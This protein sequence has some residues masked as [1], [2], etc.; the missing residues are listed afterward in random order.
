MRALPDDRLRLSPS[1]L[2]NFLACRHLTSLD[3]RRARGEIVLD[4]A[5]RPDAALIA[6]KGQRHEEA[7]LEALKAEGKQVVAI[8][9]FGDNGADPQTSARATEQAMRTGAE[10]V[11]QAAFLDDDWLG[12]ADFL[13][14]IDEPSALGDWSYEAY[15]TKLARYPKPYFILQLAF[16][17]EQIGRIQGR[18]PVQMHVV[19]G[20]REVKSFRYDDFAAYVAHVRHQFLD[21][22]ASDGP[23]PYPYPVEHCDYCDWWKRCKDKRRADDH[24][25]LVAALTRQQSIRLEDGGVETVAALAALPDDATVQRLPRTTLDALHQQARLQVYT[26][27]TGE[28]IREFLPLE[29][30]RGFQRLPT[31]SA[32]D[33]FFDIEGDPYWGDDGLEYLL[34]TWT[35]DGGYEPR[36]AHDE[37]QE[38][39]A[40]EDWVDW[41]T[42]RLVEHPDLHLYHYNHYEPTALKRLMSKYGTRE[43]EVDE[44]L[45][46]KVFCDLYVVVRQA[47]RIGQESYSL[48]ELEGFYPFERDAEVTQAGG[49]ILAYEDYLDS[50]DP[51]QLEAIAEYNDDDCRSTY[52]LRNWLLDERAEAERQFDTVL[53]SRDAIEAKERSP[54]AEARLAETARLKDEL[55]AGLPE[56][57]D[58]GTP[59]QRARQLMADLLEYHRREAK[60]E[61]WAYFDRIGETPD[62]LVDDTEAVGDLALDSDLPSARRRS[63]TSIRC[64]SRP[65]STSSAPARSSTPRPR[66]SS[67]SGQSTTR[68]GSPGSSE[69]RRP[70]ASRCPA[71][72]RPFRRSTPPSRRPRSS[73]SRTAS[74]PTA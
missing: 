51:A 13:L 56:E 66:S 59:D 21:A 7:F 16:Y 11:Y 70:T 27:E 18:M 26:R 38:R 19:L 42:A 20:S 72:S 68:K 61:W 1:D 47:M 39:Q 57:E 48:K 10:V 64:G 45:R 32:A 46:R 31:P 24:L 23:P 6:E 41:V 53:P 36:W 62:E 28:R 22:L 14:R 5:P 52:A 71:L 44:L 49:S 43:A 54:E 25:S 40:F 67:R 34:G 58:E 60:P 4:K 17:T 69:A 9:T 63:R 8:P 12:F 74:S 29:Q 30:E 2:N 33:V 15:D 37:Q 3:L 65:S 73:A 55:N 50:R 35:E